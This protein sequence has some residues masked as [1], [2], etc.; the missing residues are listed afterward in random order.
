MQ[1][2]KI[3]LFSILVMVLALMGCKPSEEKLNEA[4]NA[5]NQLLAARE[6]AEETY[7]D[8][9]DTSLRPELDQLGVQVAE[10]EAIDFTKMSDKKIDEV[11]PTIETIIESYGVVQSKLTGTY[12]EETAIREENAKNI[13]I[14]CYIINK[15]GFDL[16]S[17][18]LH[19]I[20][21]DSYSD[22]LLG[23]GGTL[24]SGY[25]L[26][27]VKLEINT[28]SEAWELVVKNTNDTSFTLP[29]E[30]LKDVDKTGVSLTLEY[31]DETKTGA[32]S[33]GGYFS[34]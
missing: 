8:I 23:N 28:D 4:E 17:V 29:C 18:V 5:R 12:Q 26:M 27:G 31:D 1:K 11:L 34:N 14:D 19:D 25:T 22:N 33:F 24:A 6:A 2:K 30:S 16:N 15:M 32:V 3:V 21:T 10:I 7:L 20:T 13:E 9:A